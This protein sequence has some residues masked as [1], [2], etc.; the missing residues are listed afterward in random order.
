MTSTAD[1]KFQSVLAREINDAGHLV[2]IHHFDDGRG[3]FIEPTVEDGARLIIIRI[4]GC[5]DSVFEFAAKF[6]D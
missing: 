5:N 6:R 2:C 1:G 3:M 4:A